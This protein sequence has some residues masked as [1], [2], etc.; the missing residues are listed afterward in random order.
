MIATYGNDS[1]TVISQ[2]PCT[3]G[4]STD[5]AVIVADP[6]AIAVTFP[7]AS[8]VAIPGSFECQVTDLLEAF[9][10]VQ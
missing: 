10:E 2:I 8:T 4:L 9:S 6:S 5:I 7:L 1:I 3:L